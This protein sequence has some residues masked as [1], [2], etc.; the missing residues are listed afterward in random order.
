MY[1]HLAKDCPQTRRRRRFLRT[2]ANWEKD[3]NQ[4]SVLQEKEGFVD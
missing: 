2:S 4:P 1:G 3:L